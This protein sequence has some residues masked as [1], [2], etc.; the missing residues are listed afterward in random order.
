MRHIDPPG[1]PPFGDDISLV[2]NEAGGL[3]AGSKMTYAL[4]KSFFFAKTPDLCQF[5]IT[6]RLGFIVPCKPYGFLQFDRVEPH[7][8]SGLMSPFPTRRKIIS[9]RACFGLGSRCVDGYCQQKNKNR[10]FAHVL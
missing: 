8:S 9:G 7:K 3:S 4:A 5:H 10:V 6:G 1:L 2:Y